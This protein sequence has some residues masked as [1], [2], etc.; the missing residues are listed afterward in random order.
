MKFNIY[1]YPQDILMEYGL[2]SE[3]ALILR[4]IADMFFSTSDKFEIICENSI[5]YIWLTYKYILNEIPII[6]TERTLINRIS[7]LCE[8]GFL[9]KTVK[10]EKNNKSGTYLYFSLGKAYEKL[11]PPPMKNLQ[12]GDEKISCP[13]MK[14]FHTKDHT[15]N[16]H[17]NKIINKY[18]MP[19]NCPPFIQDIMKKYAELGL[20]SYEFLPENSVFVNC[21]QALGASRLFKAMEI[22]S[23]N[24]YA[25]T[26]SINMIFNIKNLKKALNGTYSERNPVKNK[27]TEE[28][29]YQEDEE[30]L[31]ALKKMGF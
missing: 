1:G 26:F 28:P 25:K 21:I 11:S 23:Q 14:N 6:G 20:P 5:K 30:A 10:N 22:M 24:E 9:R 7:R 15:N 17:T 13:P 4:V 18:I 27:I 3:D 31:A 2:N 19:E 29:L 16:N 12:G 8:K